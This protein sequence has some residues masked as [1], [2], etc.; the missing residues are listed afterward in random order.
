MEE[1]FCH[2]TTPKACSETKLSGQCRSMITYTYRSLTLWPIPKFPWSAFGNDSMIWKIGMLSGAYCV[3]RC[4]YLPSGP[5]VCSW[6]AGLIRVHA[7]MMDGGFYTDAPLACQTPRL[8]S[9]SSGACPHLPDL[10]VLLTCY[11]WE[12]RHASLNLGIYYVLYIM[13]ACLS[14]LSHMRNPTLL[15]QSLYICVCLFL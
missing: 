11:I 6:M 8:P 9:V 7:C 14:N 12:I 1:S 2:A 5:S 13:S 10:M 3:V 15:S 4:R